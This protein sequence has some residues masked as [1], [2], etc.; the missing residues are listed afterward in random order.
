[1]RIIKIIAAVIGALALTAIMLR[2]AKSNAMGEAQPV[3]QTNN[4][5]TFEMTT[6]PRALDNSKARIDLKIAGPVR[7]SILPVIRYGGFQSTSTV[8]MPDVVPLVLADSS[9]GTWFTEFTTGERGGYV[10]YRFD[11]LNAKDDVVASFSM[12]DSSPFET[13]FRGEV[14]KPV[15]IGHLGFMFGTVSFV[16]LAAVFGLW[17]LFGS[18]SIRTAMVFMFLAG[19]F[20]LLGGYPFGFAMNWYAF[21]TIWEGVPFGTDATDNKTQILLFYFLFVILCGLGTITK[22]RFGRD[23]FG[24]TTLGVL[25]ILSFFVMLGIYLIPHSIQFS[26]DTTY[27]VCY[28]TIAL[29][30]LVYLFGYLKSRRA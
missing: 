11:L 27:I 29:F 1:M 10:R 3:T 20:T 13:K 14:P 6:V 28:S 21:H 26:P 2:V 16:A 25:S 24:K 5:F 12:P 18:I 7:E 19:L 30:A 17:A 4:N 22:K 9:K 15:L 8:P 23:V